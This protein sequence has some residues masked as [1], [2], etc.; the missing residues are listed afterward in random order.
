VVMLG[1]TM[2]P[3][4]VP[5]GVS[6]LPLTDFTQ[7][8][9]SCEEE[10]LLFVLGLSLATQILLVVFVGFAFFQPCSLRRRQLNECQRWRY[11]S[12]IFRRLLCQ[13]DAALS[14]RVEN[15]PGVERLEHCLRVREQLAQA[16][17]IFR[18]DALKVLHPCHDLSSELAGDLYFVL[19]EEE[20]DLTNAGYG[21][22][23]DDTQSN[24]FTI[25]GSGSGPVQTV[26]VTEELLMSLLYPERCVTVK[27]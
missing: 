16:V 6:P 20:R 25:S 17:Q 14:T 23:N 9:L 26:E 18:R 22:S 4:Y 12:F 5:E 21:L 11:A 1:T 27:E 24:S 3:R 8:S 7:Q 13:V 15:I 19:E 10:S 2:L